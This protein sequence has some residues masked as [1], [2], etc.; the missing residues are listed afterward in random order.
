MTQDTDNSKSDTLY[1]VEHQLILLRRDKAWEQITLGEDTIPAALN[2]MKE[3][4]W[5][6]KYIGFQFSQAASLIMK[7]QDK[8]EEFFVQGN[9]AKSFKY[10]FADKYVP[11]DEFR[12]APEYKF[13]FERMAHKCS[14]PADTIIYQTPEGLHYMTPQEVKTTVLIT[15]SGEELWRKNK[16]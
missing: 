7:S 2:A 4:T 5:Q 13:E 11:Y 1:N 3:A 12:F 14:L 8:E 10:V 15:R 9:A 16:L 6:D